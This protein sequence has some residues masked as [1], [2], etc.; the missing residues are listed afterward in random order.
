MQFAETDG[1]NVQ[2]SLHKIFNKYT[3][4]TVSE[5]AQATEGVLT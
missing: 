5:G 1:P 3:D 4:F 2:L